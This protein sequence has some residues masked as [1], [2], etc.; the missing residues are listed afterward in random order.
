M[1]LFHRFEVEQPGGVS[2][3]SQIPKCGLGPRLGTACWC[4]DKAD[5]T[6]KRLGKQSVQFCLLFFFGI[7]GRQ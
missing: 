3:W 4:S 6:I 5:E 2:Q 7:L 1:M